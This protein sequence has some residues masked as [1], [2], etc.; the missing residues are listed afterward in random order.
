MK[1][2]TEVRR[3]QE[4]VCVSVCAYEIDQLASA[5]I[6]IITS[7]FYLANRVRYSYYF[8]L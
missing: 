7:Y 2:F 1:D 6:G 4:R 3:N 5:C 8:H